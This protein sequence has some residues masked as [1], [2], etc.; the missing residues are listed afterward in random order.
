MSE[1]RVVLDDA[2]IFKAMGGMADRILE[3]NGGADN[4]CFVGIQRGGVPLAQ[5]DGAVRERVAALRSTGSVAAARLDALEA[6]WDAAR[7]ASPWSAPPA[8]I[9][10]DLHVGNIVTDRDGLVALIDFGDVTA[11]DPAYDLAAA[12]TVFDAAGRETFIAALGTGVDAA[13]WRRAHG[14]AAAQALIMLLHSDDNPA[15]AALGR[16]ILHELT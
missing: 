9:H 14:W 12:W 16:E 8:W 11:G 5:R 7:A 6:L 3:A 2:A 1:Q 13:T 10:G 15:Y 4:L